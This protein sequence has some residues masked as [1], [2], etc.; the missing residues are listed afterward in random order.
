[1][2][3][4]TN[5]RRVIRVSRNIIGPSVPQ[6]RTARVKRLGDYPDLEPAYA[7]LAKKY[8]NPMLLGPPICDELLAL[9]RHCF[10]EEEA[11]VAVHL[12]HK[13]SRNTRKV[14]RA[15]GRPVEQIEPILYRIGF[16]KRVVFGEGPAGNRSY[17]LV[18]IL[19]GMFELV[20]I[21]ESPESLTPWHRRFAEL[22]EALFE[23][24]YFLDY[25]DRRTPALYYLPLGDAI[26]AHPMALPSDKLEVILERY[27]SFAAGNCQCRLASL[28]QDKGCGKPLEVCTAMGRWAD[29]GVDGGWLRR[30]SKKNLLEIKREA[31]FH[32]LVTWLMN[33]KSS[34]GQASCSCCGCCCKPMRMVSQFNS[35]GI[36]APPHFMPRFDAS[37]CNHCGQC[38]KACPMGAI[39]VDTH[40]KTLAQQPA[41]CIGCGLCS[42]ACQRNQAITMQPVPDYRLPYK[43]LFSMLMRNAPSL[44]R[45]YWKVWRSRQAAPEGQ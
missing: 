10:T 29:I 33:V 19:P 2:A 17:R 23:T 45:T 43:S 12:T 38:A 9:I 1:M 41:R 8:S 5:A 35:P 22:F 15:A 21:A 18:P 6:P 40:Q 16:E 25:Q 30:I 13:R 20:L 28:G 11:E 37:V 27:D 14:A 44:M 4:T 26:G 24:G 31:E 42:L 3:T 32:G 39:T 34:R 7:K 36:V